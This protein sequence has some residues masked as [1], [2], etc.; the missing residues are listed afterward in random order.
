MPREAWRDDPEYRDLWRL[1][2]QQPE[3]TA[4]R[5]VLADWL[6]EHGHSAASWRERLH[7]LTGRAPVVEQDGEIVRAGAIPLMQGNWRRLNT[8]PPPDD[9]LCVFNRDVQ[10]YRYLAE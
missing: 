5:L 3:E 2:R 10:S 7:G 4:P 6:E 8:A 9:L 1:A